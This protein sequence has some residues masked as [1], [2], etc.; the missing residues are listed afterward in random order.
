MNTLDLTNPPVPHP[1][2]WEVALATQ[3][4]YICNRTV[5]LWSHA[6]D[7]GIWI[8][9]ATCLRIEDRLILATA[10]HNLDGIESPEQIEVIPPGPSD[11]PIRVLGWGRSDDAGR[12]FPDVAWLEIPADSEGVGS[13]TALPLDGV[14]LDATH[15]EESAVWCHGYPGALVS[16]KPGRERTITSVGTLTYSK[17]LREGE[18]AHDPQETLLI[19]YPPHDLVENEDLVEFG[20]V[21]SPEGVSGGGVWRLPP[22]DDKGIYTASSARLIAIPRQWSRADHEILATPIRRF[23]ELVAK[24]I[25]EAAE[26]F[27]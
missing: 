9:T 25:P 17:A 15:N 18:A 19:E 23:L 1:P 24:N 27:S 2:A 13:L 16:F 4:D 21:P 3:Q 8:G 11:R 22:W 26:V 10:G 12:D 7:G 14:E 20:G 5:A 6:S